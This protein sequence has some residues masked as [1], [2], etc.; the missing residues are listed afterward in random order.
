MRKILEVKKIS[1]SVQQKVKPNSTAVK[2][3]R[4]EI[5]KKIN[6]DL[7]EGNILGIIGE[8]G[9]GKTTLAKIISGI[10]KPTQGEVNINIPNNGRVSQVQ[11]LFQNNSDIV[12]PLR[13]VG[14]SVEEVLRILKKDNSKQGSSIE[15]L[16][17]LVNFPE[18][19][20]QRR[21]Y[22]LSGG[23]RQRAALA[24]IIAAEPKLLILDEPFSAQDPESQYNFLQ[25]FKKLNKE[26]GI[27]IICIAHNFN[28]IKELCNELII[29][30]SGKIIEHGETEKIFTSPSHPFT[31]FLLKANE[32]NL[33][34]E[35]LL[36][37]SMLSKNEY[38]PG[39]SNKQ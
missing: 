21:G 8:S 18:N 29:L 37:N 6:F 1:Y 16:F 24:R 39:L 14:G 9:S 22:E 2:K 13:K 28:L 36:V 38:I 32:Y 25:I 30:N 20:W 19:L 33:T 23:E 35:E 31:K 10:I 34:K 4:K 17:N 15:E 5:L 3:T 11:I 27:S 26:K 7:Y 12:N